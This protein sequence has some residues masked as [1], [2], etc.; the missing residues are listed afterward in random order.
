L[1]NLRGAYVLVAGG[2]GFVGSALVRQL[3]EHGAKVISVDNHFYGT[4]ANLDGIGI[5]GD[6]TKVDADA[7]C[8]ASVSSIF[9]KYAIDYVIDC[10]GDTFVPDAYVEPKRYLDINIQTTFNLLKSA[11]AAQVKRF[12]Y[13][14]STEVYGDAGAG[15][16]SESTPLNPVNTY[17]V[18][19]LAADRL[20]YTWYLEHGLPVTVARLFNCYGPRETHPY[21]VPEIIRQLR[22]SSLLRLGNLYAERDLTYVDDTARAIIAVAESSIPDGEVVN[23]GSGVRYSVRWLARELGRLMIGDEVSIE[24]ESERLRR[25]DVDSF[26]CDNTK[27]FRLT[28]WRP[29][30]SIDDGLRRTIDWF[31]ASGSCWSWEVLAEAKSVTS[32]PLDA[33]AAVSGHSRR[34][35]EG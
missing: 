26:C 4:R 34:F 6:L 22:D 32:A 21:I 25:H 1:H 29:S 14:S 23:I 5:G 30:V 2:A 17:A 8:L 33:V 3:L 11:T 13:L 24:Q 7:L 20:C 28:T 9:E 18:S 27:L 35:S 15:F 19:K 16:L 12:V 31:H 10:I